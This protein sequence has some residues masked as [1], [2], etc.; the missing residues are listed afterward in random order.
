MR[1][2]KHDDWDDDW[3]DDKPRKREKPKDDGGILSTRRIVV[4]LVVIAVAAILIGSFARSEYDFSEVPAGLLG[5]WTCN[6]PDSSDL[7][8]E[9]RRD[10][11][12]FGTGG[13]GTVT[14]RIVGVDFE[15][16]GGI[17]RYKV[18]YRDLAGKE[19]MKEALLPESERTLRFTDFPGA[20]WVRYE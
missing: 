11:I 1:N 15:H 20:E 16:V 10:S 18:F 17:R 8:V 19:H 4:G 2:R 6:D 12:V 13:T 5:M 14:H 3:D 9:F 7:W